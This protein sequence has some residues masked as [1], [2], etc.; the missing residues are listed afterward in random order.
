MYTFTNQ[1]VRTWIQVRWWL[2]VALLLAGAR[3]GQAAP[4]LAPRDTARPAPVFARRRLVM[5]IDS[6]Y[7][8]INN[9]FSIINGVK[10]GLEWRGR[11]RTGA[12]FYFLSSR[13]PTRLEPPDN[14][15]D[16]A[17]ATL[18]FYNVAL[19]GEYIVLENR[20]WELGANLQ[21]GMGA[22][23]IEYTNEDYNRV[24][25]PRDFIALIEPSMAAQMRLFSWASLGAGAGWRQPLFVPTVV[26]REVS[27]PIFYLR[28]KILIGPLIK[29]TRHHDP[30]FSQRELRIHGLDRTTRQRFVR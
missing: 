18:R 8:I 2:L 23:R 21:G 22:V 16:E 1:K 27:G 6:R 28:A 20:R 25:S 15:A 12:A 24:R 19:Y 11:V 4:D 30:L 5:Q 9:H 3:P 7:S 29:L 10:L 17:D 26:R 13:I 14:A